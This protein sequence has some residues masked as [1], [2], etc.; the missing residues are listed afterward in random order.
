MG[1]WFLEAMAWTSVAWAMAWRMR[2][3]LRG[4]FVVLKATAVF[5]ASPPSRSTFTRLAPEVV[6]ATSARRRFS[7]GADMLATSSSPLASMSVRLVAS[8]TTTKS[9]ASR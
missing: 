2:T 1:H 4:G 8:R 9:T 7:H 6:A 3:S 5:S